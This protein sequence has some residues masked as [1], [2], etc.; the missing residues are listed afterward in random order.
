[1]CVYVCTCEGL[2]FKG[3]GSFLQYSNRLMITGKLSITKGRA[4]SSQQPAE[5]Q[6]ELLVQGP[7]SHSESS[8][9]SYLLFRPWMP[10]FAPAFI[11]TLGDIQG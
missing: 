6:G 10:A 4:T 8:E 9:H 2:N 1:M 5:H 3:L 7:R 11:H